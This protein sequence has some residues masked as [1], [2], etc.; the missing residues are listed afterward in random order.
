MTASLS[1]TEIMTGMA[2]V[3]RRVRE[4]ILADAPPLMLVDALTRDCYVEE[5]LEKQGPGWL[6]DQVE[7][8][9]QQLAGAA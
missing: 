7:I 6:V 3:L 5:F 8:A 2:A 4:N 9:K 1:E